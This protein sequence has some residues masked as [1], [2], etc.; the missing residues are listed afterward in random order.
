MPHRGIM[1][2]DRVTEIFAMPHREIMSI[3]RTDGD[4]RHAP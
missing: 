2:I 3:D 1:S 4:F